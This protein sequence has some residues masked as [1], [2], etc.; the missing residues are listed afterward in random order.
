METDFGL[1]SAVAQGAPPLPSLFKTCFIKKKNSSPLY[2]LNNYSRVRLLTLAP[3]RRRRLFER[4][5]IKYKTLNWIARTIR[6]MKGS[7]DPM[8]RD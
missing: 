3:R 5:K 1:K 6:E 8:E 7:L 4:Q 2:Y